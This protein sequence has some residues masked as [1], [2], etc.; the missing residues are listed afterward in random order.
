MVGPSAMGSEKGT[1]SS[2][3]SAPPATRARMRGKVSSGEGSPAVMKGMRALRP[4]WARLAKVVWI[5]DIAKGAGG[6]GHPGNRKGSESD[7][8]TLGHGVHVLVPA[9]REIHQQELV[10]GQG[11]GQARGIGQGMGRLQ[12]RDDAFQSA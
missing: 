11:R 4:L 9:T 7:A 12:G 8:G 10:P 1:P 6:P 2:M 5:L 3:M